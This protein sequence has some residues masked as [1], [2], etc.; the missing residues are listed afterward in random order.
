MSFSGRPNG[1]V[2]FVINLSC[3]NMENKTGINYLIKKVY[4]NYNNNKKMEMSITLLQNCS[5]QSNS[6]S[7]CD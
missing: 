5:V 2:V 1:T 4:V 7:Q 3:K 6:T